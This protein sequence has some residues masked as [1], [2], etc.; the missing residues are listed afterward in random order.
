MRKIVG[1]LGL[2][3]AVTGVCIGAILL[4]GGNNLGMYILLA[5]FFGFTLI[6]RS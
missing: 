1:N 4:A 6:S 3:L 2:S 5:S